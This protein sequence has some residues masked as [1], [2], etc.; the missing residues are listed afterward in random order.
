MSRISLHCRIV[1][2]T[3]FV[4][5]ENE[6]SSLDERLHLIFRS[7]CHAFLRQN[8]GRTLVKQTERNG[9]LAFRFPCSFYWAGPNPPRLRGRGGGK[10]H[11]RQPTNLSPCYL[12]PSRRFLLPSPL[13][14]IALPALRSAHGVHPR[15][16]TPLAVL[17]GPPRDPPH[18]HAPSLARPARFG[19]LPRGA[20]PAH[21]PARA[22]S[23]RRGREV[24]RAGR[25]RGGGAGVGA[26]RPR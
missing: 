26:A 18:A 15:A 6:S 11:P 19:W 1:F 9:P 3:K 21:V 5:Y 20:R 16:H 10:I 4:S 22:R 13:D 24:H 17:L 14:G 23:V 7:Q 2:S 8:F 25:V 12:A